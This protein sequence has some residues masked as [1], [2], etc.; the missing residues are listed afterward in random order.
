MRLDDAGEPGFASCSWPIWQT[1][2]F[3]RCFQRDYLKVLLPLAIVTLSFVHLLAH[4]LI[5]AAKLKGTLGYEPL[6][7]GPTTL[8]P[9]SHTELPRDE[10][11]IGESDEEE[12]LVIEGGRLAL[13]KTTTRGSI[14]QA[15]IP[16]GQTLSIW[17]EELSVIGLVAIN[18][19]A[20]ATGAYGKKWGSIAAVAGL[21]T[22]VYALLLTSLRLTLGNTQWR[23]P[24]LWN[25]TTIIYTFQW[26]FTSVIFRS[27]L[28][29][30]SS[31]LTQTL[32]IAEF[33]LSTLLFVMAICTRKGNKTILLEWEDG[34]APGRENLASL[35]SRYTFSW[36][37]SIVYEGW[38]EP[39]DIKRVWNLL[40][41]DKAAA[42]L[43][44]YRLLKKTTSLAVHLL[45]FFKGALVV[46]AAWA[47][48]GGALTFAPTL[49]L[50]AILEYVEDPSIAPRNVL[51]L[52][53]ILLPLSDVLRSVADGQALW[54]GRKICINLRAIL[55]GEI[56]AKAL[57]RKA[58]AGND[59]DLGAKKDDDK[60]KKGIFSRV[61]RL[62]GLS[63]DNTASNDAANA[64][65]SKGKTPD[66]DEQANLGT[67]I[68]LMSV[69]SFKVSE[70][71]SYLHFL[72]AAAPTQLL[73]AIILLYQVMGYSAIPGLIIMAL[74]LPVN[75]AFGK[76]F[77][78]S[79][80]RI[81]AATDKR[82]H[83][84]NE[85]LQNIRI[86]KYFAWEHRFSQ[87]VDEKRRAELK[88][89]RFRFMIWA[90]AVAVWNTVPILITFFSFL[91]YTVVEQKP[92]YPSVAFTAISL[93][94]LLRYP[95]D[96]LGDMIAH[97]QESAVSID[98]IEEFLSEEETEKFAQLG[99]DNVDE[100]GNRVIGFKNATFIWGSRTA[101]AEDGSMA[102]RLLDLDLDFKIGK[103][104]VITGPTGSGKTSLLMALLGE[105]TIM[106]GRVFLPGGRSRE[107]VR[108]DPET[109]L[110][111]T[112]AYV[113]QQAW[114][115][116][117]N[118]KD[119]ILFS[120]PYDEQRYRDVIVACALERDLEI[121]DN[122]DETLVG[123]KG[124]TLS[125]GQ[126]QRISLA[127]AVYSNSKHLLLDDCLS[128]VDS[129]TAQWIF[130]NCIM[131][132]LMRN[133][134]CILVSH[135]IPLC[136]PHADYVVTMANGRVTHQGTPQELIGAGAL[137]EDVAVQKS[138]PGSAHISRVPSRV[139][140]S[141]G[142]ESGATLINDADGGSGD[143]HKAKDDPAKKKETKK[144]DAME[145]TRSTGA[146]KWPVLKL[147][148]GSMGGW[149]FWIA[150]AS[151]FATQQFS[152][153]ASSFWI[154]EWS[155]QYDTEEKAKIGFNM[156]SN[157]YSVQTLSPTYFASIANYVKGNSTTWMTATADS[158][159]P[160]PEVNVTYYLIVLA[161]IGIAG[162]L[163]ALFRDLWLFKGSISASW[164]L[165]DGLMRSVTGAK[166]KFFDVTP[167]GQMMNRFSKD[168]ENVDQEVAPIAI[169]VM[170]CALA[171]IVTVILIAYITPMFLVAGVFIALAYYF[172]GSFYLHASRDLKRLES[173]ERSPLFQ[174]FG[175][176]LSGVTTIRAYGDERR[177]IRDNL[178]RI[179]TQLRPFIY[180]WA[181][182]R[183]LAFRTDCLG[184]VVA[185]FAGV[186]VI[187]GLGKID[188]GSAGISLSYAIGFADNIL[189]LVRLYALNEQN[190]NSVER[191][192]EYL[193][194]EQEAVAV[195]EDNRP[196][197]N[198][199]A[200]GAV[201]FINYSTRYREELDPVLRNL[202]FRIEAR[203]K[204]GIVGRTG[205]GKS[206]LTLAIFRALEADEGKILIDG[207]D[208]GLIGLRDLREAITIVPQEPTLFMGT[209]RTNLDPFDLYTDEEI[210]TALRRVHLIQAGELTSVT[211]PA[212]PTMALPEAT[213]ATDSI[214]TPTT[215]TT[216][217]NNKNIFLDLSSP[218]TESG[219]NLSQGQRQLLC[220]ARALL[221]NPT[222]L[223]MDEAT[224]SIDYATDSAIQETIRELTSTII[225]I[226]HRL[227]TIVDYDK[228]LVLDKGEIVEYGHPWELMRK[229]KQG[230][231][232]GKGVATTGA[233]ATAGDRGGVFR[234][235]C[236][237]SGDY[238][239][240]AA[241]AKKAWKAKQLVDVD[242]D[243]EEEE[244]EDDDEA[245]NREEGK[246]TG[247][248]A[249]TDVE[250]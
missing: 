41:K 130:N 166:F 87:I 107:D 32:A 181:A 156:N 88:A 198:W 191:I 43:S 217:A 154:R 133:R 239:V 59:N 151:V 39:L 116:N 200:Q 57:R 225:T 182:N 111:E 61:K 90:A 34:I 237:T 66:A 52:Y 196:P 148:L 174:Q 123:E 171:I 77:N 245:G 162:A 214:N 1:D 84:T 212:T 222:V 157:S 108:P 204:I 26:L 221:K 45:K 147:Y 230:E 85:I 219:N 124:I 46:Q 185:F 49:L 51:W 29:R 10:Q 199:P 7:A 70:I 210:F 175:E 134:S 40:P 172:L 169:G 106:K 209:I 80:K 17:I 27:V 2:D 68:N 19:I 114:L 173:V 141:V 76:G 30:A 240:L 227:Q 138:A 211:A 69:D 168:L 122:G 91:V 244:E 190:M 71:T 94:M 98:R 136:V 58:A 9:T 167:L 6:G 14:V 155:N 16:P 117:A 86:I 21:V 23:V 139:P 152:G 92:L 64:A 158:G 243:E 74:L 193:D 72:V 53:V 161:A 207:V 238:A 67:I 132:P 224:A 5:R 4:N 129:H 42:V 142:E 24:H 96:Q 232:K 119:N 60:K 242:D 37:D 137:P 79:Q 11:P 229:R 55:V 104:N 145:E 28:I 150:A 118:I 188:P 201:E 192:K 62:L 247:G 250:Q 183:W 176:T 115:V 15:D 208:V 38:K 127:R 184:D 218:V 234:S 170:S 178:G 233:G 109:G 99:V 135:N 159:T 101:V 126:K 203:E 205:A 249:A 47:V 54:I 223:V 177:F 44:N 128:A 8:S 120:A 206:S 187:I 31:Q 195:V 22:W 89:L 121:L 153:V 144:V 189:W 236:E 105:M 13:A 35:F 164:K 75:I 63:K 3:T 65:A 93:F 163:A 197:E 220:L 103:L 216:A 186:F 36:V 146:V 180:M 25:H 149:M 102:F 248:A 100:N 48:L 246:E 241:A 194:V 165:H 226:A 97:V 160:V 95:L 112:C 228:V 73:V 235:M 143:Q 18:A 12:D 231:G 20:L 179:N 131:G 81:M 113:A 50:R 110:A 82:I 125:G 202:S 56:Y 215:P 213:T 78:S 83:T 140:S 33:A